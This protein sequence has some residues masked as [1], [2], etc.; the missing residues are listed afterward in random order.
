M[1]PA[2][3][4][5]ICAESS[6]PTLELLTRSIA[7]HG[8]ILVFLNVLFEQC[9]VP[10]PA[11]PV[12]LVTGALAAR[13]ELSVAALLGTAVAACLIADSAWYFAG[14]RFGRKVLRVLCRVSLSPDGCVRQT[15]SIFERWGAGSLMVAKFVPGF[16]SVATALAG[17]L[18]IRRGRF[19][20]FDAIGAA[21][22]AGCGLALG[23]L[24]S[25]AI[26]DIIATLAAVGKWG[27]ALLA[28][29]LALFI[30]S[31][32]W[33]RHRFERQLRMERIGV[34]TLVELIAAGDAPI[35]L[36][37]RSGIA[38]ADGQIPGALSLGPDEA[39][40]LELIE[41]VRD[42]PIVVYCACPNDASAA[43]MARKLGLLGFTDVRPLLGGV[44]AWTTAGGALERG[45]GP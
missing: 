11:Y 15:E 27:L 18:G 31:K 28:V 38:R 23:W 20:F 44:E 17:A 42:T 19:I 1:I 34:A 6:E 12:L 5:F 10:L 41:S 13:G 33:Q 32:W 8:L 7:E 40:P 24:F 21:L 29:A 43:L 4:E 26:D 45:T 3:G 35:I 14:Q 22:W 30:A 16:A 9:G 36:D 39:F 25:P 2:L 37:V